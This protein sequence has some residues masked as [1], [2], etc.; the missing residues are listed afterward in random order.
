MRAAHLRFEH[1]DMLW[2]Q[3]PEGGIIFVIHDFYHWQ[4]FPDNW[5]GVEATIPVKTPEGFAAPERG[6][7]EIWVEFKMWETAG[8]LAAEYPP[9]C[10]GWALKSP[11]NP[12]GREVTFEGRCVEGDDRWIVTDS[13]GRGLW[14]D[15]YTKCW[16]W[17]E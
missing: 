7:R 1:G 13:D 11:G 10:L 6:F 9:I 14:L 17:I 12:S 15:K 2:F 16:T 3:W 5:S 8:M 4:V